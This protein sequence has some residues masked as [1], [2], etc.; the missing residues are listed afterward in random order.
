MEAG[1]KAERLLAGVEAARMISMWQFGC[2]LKIPSGRFTL[3]LLRS[4]GKLFDMADN[5][6]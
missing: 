4:S 6:A 5:P 3:A 1:V 2:V